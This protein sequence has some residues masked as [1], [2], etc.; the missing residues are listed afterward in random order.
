[1]AIANGDDATIPTAKLILGKEYPEDSALTAISPEDPHSKI[2]A[3][4]VRSITEVPPTSIYRNVLYGPPKQVHG[5]GIERLFPNHCFYTF[6]FG[7]K[8]ASKSQQLL[9]LLYGIRFTIAVAKDNSV[10][11]LEAVTTCTSFAEFLARNK[12]RIGNADEARL[13]SDACAEIH[14]TPRAQAVQKISDRQWRFLVPT[15]QPGVRRD[16]LVELDQDFQVRSTKYE[17]V[18]THQDKEPM[19]KK[20]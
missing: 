10:F 1:M 17:A 20:E 13:V 6:T 18:S 2:V 9:G 15:E 5:R 14:R 19:K 16:V 12:V 11:R 8:A 7:Q 4:E 3:D